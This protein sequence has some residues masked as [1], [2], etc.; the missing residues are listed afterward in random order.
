LIIK[1]LEEA[2]YKSAVI[3]FSLSYN[4]NIKRAKE[5]LPIYAFGKVPGENKFLRLM[6]LWF[7]VDFPRLLWPECDQYKVS[8]TTL[9]E[10]TVHT[11]HKRTLS[12][13]DFII[14]IDQEM[15]DIINKKIIL[16][17]NK[18]IDILELKSHLP[19]GFLQRRIWHMNYANLQNIVVQRHNHKIK[20]WQEFIDIALSQIKHPEFIIQI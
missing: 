9:S 6:E 3:G 12:Q 5:L 17:Q 11:L 4:T 7:D 15:L 10:S 8:T 16:F 13:K 1:L 2:G 18:E 20:L 19:E 14:N